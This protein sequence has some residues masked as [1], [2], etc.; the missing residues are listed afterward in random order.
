MKSEVDKEFHLK[1]REKGRPD[2]T[3]GVDLKLVQAEERKLQKERAK[4]NQQIQTKS[5]L[6]IG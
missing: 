3:L 1:Q 6:D 2:S 4:M 5:L